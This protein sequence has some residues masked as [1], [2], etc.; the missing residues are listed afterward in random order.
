[1][2]SAYAVRFCERL[3]FCA[4]DKAGFSGSLFLLVDEDVSGVRNGTFSEL[5]Q[6]II[7]DA[8]LCLGE[9]LEDG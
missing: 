4:G 8:V 7:E 9:L 1:M 2:Q 3:R 6:S 5:V